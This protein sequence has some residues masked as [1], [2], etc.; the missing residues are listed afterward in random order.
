MNFFSFDEIYGKKISKNYDKIS[1]LAA[2]KRR[3]IA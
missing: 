1:K 2:N 3:K